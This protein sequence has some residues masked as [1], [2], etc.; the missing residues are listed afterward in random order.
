MKRVTSSYGRVRPDSAPGC[1][2]RFDAAFL[3]YIARFRRAKRARMQKLLEGFAG[4]VHRFERPR[5][6]ARWLAGLAR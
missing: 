6:T 2:E 1:P 3:L 5:D 4:A